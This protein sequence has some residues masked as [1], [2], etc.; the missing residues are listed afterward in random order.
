MVAGSST[1]FLQEWLL[2]F[3]WKT[4]YL[5]KRDVHDLTRTTSAYPSLL[6]LCNYICFSVENGP[7]NLVQ[8]T[9]TIKDCKNLTKSYQ[10][11]YYDE[12][13]TTKFPLQQTRPADFSATVYSRQQMQF[14]TAISKGLRISRSLSWCRAP[15]TLSVRW[16]G[17]FCSA[18]GIGP[19]WPRRQRLRLWNRNEVQLKWPFAVRTKLQVVENPSTWCHKRPSSKTLE[20]RK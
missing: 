14:R 5:S 13:T 15:W 3:W 2:N 20:R 4:S 7:L 12:R 8:I 16:S 11:R 18:V 9:A 19:L 10:I 17:P 1:Y 6:D